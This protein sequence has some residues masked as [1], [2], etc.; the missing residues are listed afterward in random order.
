MPIT[1]D[2][3]PL[4]SFAVADVHSEYNRLVKAGAGA[5]YGGGDAKEAVE[6]AASV[7][8]M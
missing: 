3:I 4:A 2:G 7:V 6:W 8:L 1:S 5:G